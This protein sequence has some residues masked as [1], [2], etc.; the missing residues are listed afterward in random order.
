MQVKVTQ[1]K[2]AWAKKE[3]IIRSQSKKL[4]S[5][6][7]QWISASSESVPPG[8]APLRITPHSC[9]D[10]CQQP[11]WKERCL[12]PQVWQE[13]CGEDSSSSRVTCESLGGGVIYLTSLVHMSTW[14]ISP[15]ERLWDARQAKNDRYHLERFIF[16]VSTNPYPNLDD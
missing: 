4:K 10:G 3:T 6:S 11:Q 8:F 9:Q 7:D 12:C 2:M 14:L 16:F 13:Q 15:E 1:F 5:R